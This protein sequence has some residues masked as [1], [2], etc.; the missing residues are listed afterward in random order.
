MTSGFSFFKVRG[1]H[2]E[3]ERVTHVERKGAARD[4][5]S[6]AGLERFNENFREI[7][8]VRT[9]LVDNASAF[10]SECVEK[11]PSDSLRILIVVGDDTEQP[12]IEARQA[13]ARRCRRDCYDGVAASMFLVGVHADRCVCLTARARTDHADHVRVIT[14]VIC[15]CNGIV[16]IWRSRN[17]AKGSAPSLLGVQEVH[18]DL[19]TVHQR[20]TRVAF[21]ARIVGSAN[22]ELFCH[23]LTV[24]AAASEY[25]QSK[26]C[27]ECV[28]MHRCVRRPGRG[29][30]QTHVATRRVF[31]KE[32][33]WR[34]QKMASG[35]CHPTSA[36]QRGRE[37]VGPAA[38]IV[39][40]EVAA[41]CPPCGDMGRAQ[42]AT[43]YPTEEA[44]AV[45]AMPHARSTST[46]ISGKSRISARLVRS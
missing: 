28:S 37:R 21:L 32:S 39:E 40:G 17:H 29:R 5:R 38:G 3:G 42:R 35:E 22:P 6:I 7:A 9:A 34:S 16:K 1:I 2:G 13:R 18:G 11:K 33:A 45:S 44:T 43:A 46:M 20:D 26:K 27:N 41:R 15:D 30:C 31:Y 36:S 24:R 10:Q 14:Q 23:A 8:T 12:V 19:R 4:D 25:R